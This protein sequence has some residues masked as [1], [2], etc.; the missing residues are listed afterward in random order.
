M[1]EVI[2]F[3]RQKKRWSGIRK[4]YGTIVL[5]PFEHMMDVDAF[6]NGLIEMSADGEH[7]SDQSFYDYCVHHNLEADTSF[8]IYEALSLNGI[9]IFT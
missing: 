1:G 5:E 8:E 3:P 4:A 9:F 7:L 2:I 6:A